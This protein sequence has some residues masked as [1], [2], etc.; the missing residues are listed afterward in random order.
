MDCFFWFL[1]DFCDICQT[2]KNSPV[3]EIPFFTG[4]HTEWVLIK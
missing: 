4:K 1:R 2:F 3:Y